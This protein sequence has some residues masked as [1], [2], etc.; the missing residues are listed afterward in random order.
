LA[1]SLTP[2]GL[3][4]TH[5]VR[6]AVAA[7]IKGLE[8]DLKSI[9]ASGWGPELIPDDEILQS[10]FPDVLAKIEQDQ[11]RI[12]EL[13]GLFAAVSGGDEEE[14]DAEV[15]AE[16]G[17]SPKSLVKSLKEEKKNLG[18]EIKEAKKRAKNE[19]RGGVP[20]E[21]AVAEKRIAEIDTQLARHVALED[22]LKTLKAHIREVEKQKKT[23]IASARAK[24]SEDEAKALIL[25]RF[26]RLLTEQLDG[27][28]RQ[29]QRAFIAAIE[30]LWSKYAVTT[31][32]ILAER[33]R[34]AVQLN[35]FLKELGYE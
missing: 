2:Q 27:Y 21:V 30:N 9:A 4:T 10:Q 13:E 22:E 26:K 34:E 32:Q 23:L 1:K 24:I 5:Q 8:S 28:L 17:V 31:K 18:G 12:A 6:G 3:L 7:Y 14:G 29:Y 33:D 20:A 11:A 19:G 35:Q 16:N 15:D 25:A